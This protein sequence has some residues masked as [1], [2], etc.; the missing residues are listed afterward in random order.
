MTLLNWS[1]LQYRR[2]SMPRRLVVIKERYTCLDALQV[3]LFPLELPT[4]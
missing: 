3:A 2:M 1:F 4:N